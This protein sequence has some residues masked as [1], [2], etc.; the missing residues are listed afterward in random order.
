MEQIAATVSSVAEGVKTS[1][2]VHI[3]AA[4]LGVEMPICEAVYQVLHQGKPWRV[5][6][7]ELQARPL[8]AEVDPYTLLGPARTAAA[9]AAESPSK[10]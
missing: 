6:L 4:Q 2:S 7:A 1:L 9:V 8:S 10:L 3:L 5:A